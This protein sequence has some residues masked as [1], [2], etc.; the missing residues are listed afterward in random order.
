MM[1]GNFCCV[2]I[3]SIKVGLAS[4]SGGKK[5]FHEARNPIFGQKSDFFDI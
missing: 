1:N 3:H 5:N 4:F 2:K